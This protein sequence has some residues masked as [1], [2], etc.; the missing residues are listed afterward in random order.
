[1]DMNRRRLGKYELQE[2]LGSGA[3]GTIWKAFNTQQRRFVTI[4]IVPVD[5]Q[6]SADF[7]SRFYREAQILT[8]LH[9]PNIVPILDFH[10]SQSGNEAYIIM[11]YV[12][13]LSLADYLSATAHMGK[14]PS[15]ADIVGLLTP[16]ANALDYAH[17][18][19]VIHGALRPAAI[20]LGKVD[21]TS[22]SPGEPK[23]TD[24]G[25][26]HVQNPLALPLDNA[27]YIS[28]EIAQG[29]TSTNQS[30]L[31]ALG[32]ILYEMC[33]GALP[34]HGDTTGDISMQHIHATPTSPVLINPHIPPTLTA[35]IMRSL[36]RDPA[37][38]YSTATTLVSSVAKALNISMPE[39]ISHSHSLT[40]AEIPLSLSGMDTIN[41]GNSPTYLSQPPQLSLSNTPS[42]TPVVAGK[43]AA[44]Q[45]E[46]PQSPIISYS[47]PILPMTPTGSAPTKQGTEETYV[48]KTPISQLPLAN[49]AST[50]I[51]TS[52]PGPSVPPR[53]QGQ[54]IPPPSPAPRVPRRRSR[55][56]YT[57]LVAALL[58]VLA[59]SAAGA[60]LF[61]T[62]G[63]PPTQPIIVGHAFFLSSGILSSNSKNQGITDKLQI[64]L[65]NIADPQPGKQ[66][67]AWLLSDLHIDLPDVPI[68]PLPLNHR[69]VTMTYSDPQH[70]NLLTNYNHFL[71][72]EE[73]A[74]QQ[75][76]NPSLDINTWRYSIV[77]S[78]KPNPE[79]TINHFS[80]FDHL[81][82]LLSQ[83]PKLKLIGLGGGLD[84]WLFRNTSK[85][86]AAAGS[87]RDAQKG[88]TPAPNNSACAFLHRSLV[89]VLDFLDGS[90][91]VQADVP[92]DTPLLIDPTIAR[93]ALLETDVVHQQP[94]GYLRH[95]GSHLREL[96]GSPGV[97]P[98]QRTLAIRITQAINNVQGWLEAVHTDAVKLE[99]MD[100]SQLSQPGALSI[101][102]DLFTQANHAFVG[103]FDPNTS[104]VK[105]GVVQV[106]N[107]IQSL[108]T[109]DVT[110]CAIN[111]GKNTCS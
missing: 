81:R 90:A 65:Q 78:T 23:L 101:L 68:G 97:T 102:N 30:D 19:N 11:D 93:V 108:A 42:V 95:I 106:H 107:N 14:I 16:I 43:E 62:R 103:Q 98:E 8:A 12:E 85:L 91:Y 5:A 82:H 41:A 73:D 51:A 21:A 44:I 87:A 67:Y 61:Y 20:L 35:V 40:G 57:A 88:C 92:L 77:F 33:T 52:L 24:F 75:P 9:H 27:S 104:T 63:T 86:L 99:K 47:T 54:T 53:T 10:M 25:L 28:P 50:P 94:P 1:M 37:A 6:S 17:Q 74:N 59:G 22:T 110:P 4:K 3:V 34:F 32:V 55:W 18:R 36:A 13:G 83:D 48:Q 60:Y 70:N 69:Q 26:N 76:P 111:N 89:R 80:Q 39:S 49:S 66:Y 105:E 7:T 31:Y 56:L 15:P 2:R 96:T 100:N 29:L 72:T 84:I 45:P 38:R 58:F 46:L 79:D 71:I 64:N 109:F